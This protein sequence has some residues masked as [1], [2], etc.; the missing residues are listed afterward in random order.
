MNLGRLLD[1]AVD[2]RQS[3]ASAREHKYPFG[4]FSVEIVTY[5]TSDLKWPSTVI[6]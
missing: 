3:I 1:T 5:N 2:H 6:S 4:I